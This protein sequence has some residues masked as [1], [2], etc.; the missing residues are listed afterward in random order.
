MMIKQ[1]EGRPEFRRNR[2][3]DQK[4]LYRWLKP[5]NRQYMSENDAKLPLPAFQVYVILN[6]DNYSRS[7]LFEIKYS[8]Q[9]QAILNHQRLGSGLG[10]TRSLTPLLEASCIC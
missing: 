5:K 6:M 10:S 1:A 8:S 4:M 7:R 9:R 3:Y 2:P